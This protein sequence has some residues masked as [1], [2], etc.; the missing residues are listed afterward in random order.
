MDRR[1]AIKWM[2]AAGTMVSALNLLSFGSSPAAAGYGRDPNLL[3]VY[4]P[5]DLWPLTFNRE[6]RQTATALCDVIIPADDQSPAAS[7]VGVPDFIDE[8]ISAPYLDQQADRKEILDGLAWLDAE[9]HKRFGKNFADLTGDQ[10]HQICDDI[11]YGPDAKPQFRTAA[12]FFSKFRNLT[13]SGF[14][15]SPQGWKDLKYIGNVPLAQFDGPP[16]EVLAYLK[17]T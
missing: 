6:Q 12:R 17:L 3:E 14:Y 15:T 5:G 4:K 7:A 11:C 10:Q 16:P 13:V 8:W 2:F 1:E 9:S